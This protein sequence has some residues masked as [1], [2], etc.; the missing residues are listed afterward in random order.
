MSTINWSEAASQTFIDFGRYFVPERE[1]QIAA[2]VDL[3]PAHDQPFN[4]LEL[5]CGEGLAGGRAAGA[6]PELHGLWLRWLAGHA[7]SRAAAAGADM[8]TAFRRSCSTWPIAPGAR[9]SGRF[10]QWSPR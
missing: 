9:S 8:A 4:I 1:Q 5:C 6:L 10:M 3:I 7:R 2:F